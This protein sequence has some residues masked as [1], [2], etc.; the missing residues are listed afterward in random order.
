MN[1]STI[2]TQT[3]LAKCMATDGR[4]VILH[5]QRQSPTEP[6]QT[7]TLLGVCVFYS[8]I[9]YAECSA[10]SCELQEVCIDCCR[11]VNVLIVLTTVMSDRG[12]EARCIRS[13]PYLTSPT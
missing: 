3:V 1:V 5:W 4:Q 12:K 7:L 6:E 9:G 2:T 8:W 11:M 10:C 13:L